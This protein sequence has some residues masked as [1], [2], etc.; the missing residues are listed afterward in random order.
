MNGLAT[1]LTRPPA[2]LPDERM[3]VTAE[4]VITSFHPSPIGGGILVGRDGYGLLHRVVLDTGV[5]ARDPQEGESW[6]VTGPARCHPEFGSQIHARVALP[7]LPSGRTIVRYLATN[8]RFPGVGWKTADRLWAALGERLY[9]ALQGADAGVVARI[10]G[11][12][13][14]VV[15]ISGFGL[16]AD[17]VEVFRWLDR[18][19]VSP[20]TA[21]AAAGLWGRGAVQRISADPYALALLEP[22]RTVDERALRLGLSPDDRRRRLSAVDE[23]FARKWRVGRTA[24][25]REELVAHCTGVLGSRCLV[26]SVQTVDDAIEAGRAIQLPGELLQSRAAWFMEREVERV[27]LDRLAWPRPEASAADLDD[28]LDTYGADRGHALTA[29]QRRAVRMVS[30]SRVSVLCGGAGTGKTTAVRAVLAMSDRILATLPAADRVAAGQR[31]VAL[32]GRA[33]KRISEA[34]GREASTIARFLRRLEAGADPMRRGLLVIDEA[35]MLDLPVLYRVL[36]ALPPE[37]DLLFVGDPAQ[38][39]P[40]GPGSPF[41]QMARSPAI[42]RTTLDVVHRQEERTGI[43]VVAAAIRAGHLPALSEFDPGRPFTPGVFLLSAER[44]KVGEAAVEVF[45]AM[46]GPAP[47]R[48]Q[49]DALHGLDLQVLCPLKNGPDGSKTVNEA[50]EREW[51]AHQERI[52]GWGLSV[53][54][55]VLWLR[56][57]YDKAPVVA[58]DG[59]QGVDPETG[60]PVFAGFMNGALGIVRRPVDSG[61]WVEFDDGAADRI[62]VPD[63]ERL[64]RG[65]A[66]S[67]HKAQGS[68]FRRVIIPVTRTRLLDRALLYTAV[69]RGVETVV[70]V[71]NP[72]EI[73]RAVEAPPAVSARP[74]TLQFS[75][76]G[77]DALTDMRLSPTVSAFM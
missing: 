16:L 36:V 73:R 47:A 4:L 28:V 64:T 12:E 29:G 66:I 53:G 8:S 34:T 30:R 45:R 76:P 33:A 35:S 72:E 19:G 32:A 48:G 71:G 65:W 77:T 49:A 11:A 22:W 13:R 18:Y 15:V 6:R 27:L 50:I 37:V 14:A 17:E 75:L 1:P 54:S 21:A 61:A 23:A 9:D 74:E 44:G 68:E 69:T 26:P 58:E 56:N 52:P 25:T 41:H 40:I 5:A 43:P 20:R 7:L 46:A 38:L 3:D 31:Q 42:P 59:T 10:I 63:L 2:D 60:R 67:V 51:M 62:R 39:P 24:A 57:D 70:L 55:K